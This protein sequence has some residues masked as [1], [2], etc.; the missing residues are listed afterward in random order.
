MAHVKMQ[1]VNEDGNI[2]HI[3]QFKHRDQTNIPITI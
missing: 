1:K 3:I 2:K